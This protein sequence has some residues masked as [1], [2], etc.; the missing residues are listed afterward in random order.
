MRCGLFKIPPK[1]RIRYSAVPMVPIS[2][3][4]AAFLVTRHVGTTL[5]FN[6]CIGNSM[7]FQE[8]TR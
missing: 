3:F 1:P 2:R 8:G 7:G 4:A 5:I 6:R